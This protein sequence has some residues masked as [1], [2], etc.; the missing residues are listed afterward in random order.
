LTAVLEY[1]F[2]VTGEMALYH[3]SLGARAFELA[4]ADGLTG[5]GRDVFVPH[6][7]RGV[8]IIALPSHK[9]QPALST[10]ETAAVAED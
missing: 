7:D 10:P 8:D 9:E 1:L 3:N 6:K 4:V 5:R 2:E